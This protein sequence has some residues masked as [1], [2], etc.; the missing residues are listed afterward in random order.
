M[1]QTQSGLVAFMMLSCLGA[2]G[3]W[4]Q[5]DQAPINMGNGAANWISV[6]DVTRSGGTLTFREVQIEGDGW[7]VI[8]P[9]EDGAPNGDKYVAS[10]FLH[11][12]SNED[13]EIV[14][15]KGLARGEMFIVMLHSD[16]NAN[17]ILDFVFVDDLNVMDRAVFEGNTMIGHAIPAP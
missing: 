16:S 15:H 1:R 7:L 12:G 9:F 6:E 4:A 2:E 17:Q 14:V 11:S 8:H 13:V 3:A 10:T 5:S